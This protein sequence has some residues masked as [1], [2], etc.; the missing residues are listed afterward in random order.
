MLSIYADWLLSV[1]LQTGHSLPTRVVQNGLLT[2]S[3]PCD[4]RTFNQRCS[5]VLQRWEFATVFLLSCTPYVHTPY[6][7]YNPT[8]G[9]LMGSDPV[10]TVANSLHCYDRSVC[11]RKAE[12]RDFL[13]T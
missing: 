7:S 12:F 11:L 3:E 4:L 9:N 13:T 2:F 1:Q 10:T 6:I 8:H 5:C